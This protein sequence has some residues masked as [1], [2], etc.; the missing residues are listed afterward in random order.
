MNMSPLF[1]IVAIAAIQIVSA[2][3]SSLQCATNES[4]LRVSFTNL[5][6]NDWNE[7]E[8]ANS[9]GLK[10]VTVRPTTP[11]SSNGSASV[12][13]SDDDS[14]ASDITEYYS[15]DETQT[16]YEKCLPTNNNCYEV[17]ISEFPINSYDIYW[18]DELVTMNQ[19]DEYYVGEFGDKIFSIEVGNSCIPI[20]NSEEEA[21]LEYKYW[22][23]IGFEDYRIEDI[24]DDDATTSNKE[25][26]L[27]CDSWKDDC[28]SN[29]IP[30]SLYT[31][32]TCLKKNKC[33][34][35]L[36]GDNFHRIPYHEDYYTSSYMLSWDGDV[37]EK[38][39][40]KQF[41]VVV[42]GDGCSTA[43]HIKCNADEEAKAEFFMHRP[44][45]MYDCENEPNLDWEIKGGVQSNDE[46]EVYASG[47]IPS[48]TNTSLYYESMC[49]PK[50]TCSFFTISSPKPREYVAPPYK[51]SL[52]GV[53]YRFK[54]M[55][56]DNNSS[57]YIGLAHTTNMGSCNVNDLCTEDEARPQLLEVEVKTPS[58]FTHDGK[59]LDAI[60]DT[61]RWTAASS[62]SSSTYSL[63][64]F[65]QPTSDLDTIY[66]T[67]ECVPCD[68]V[69]KLPSNFEATFNIL[70][71]GLVCGDVEDEGDDEKNS[72]GDITVGISDGGDGESSEGSNGAGIKAISSIVWF[73]MVAALPVYLC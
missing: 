31:K 6:Q 29:N 64:Y 72:G 69:F 18:N 54:E 39:T 46:S 42:F 8:E 55:N 61:F 28:Q 16:N 50:D 26:V 7:M 71:N 38:H 36:V 19:D 53:I 32:R 63:D 22:S 30:D 11:T 34:R 40:S 2:Q 66:R 57:D 59:S 23:N 60:S 1:S 70:P 13:A 20:C 52:D 62:S 4:L 27:R 15:Y 56:I 58:E 25:V 68:T 44:E 35:F 45:A 73:A 5:G 65:G 10:R 47:Y 33:Y 14:A 43:N 37:L 49:I 3:Q 41:D 21:I 17:T 48:C 67:V 24:T 9:F 51:L 12:V